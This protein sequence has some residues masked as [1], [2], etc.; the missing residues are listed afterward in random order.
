MVIQDEFGGIILNLGPFEG[1]GTTN[2]PGSLS[3]NSSFLYIIY[4]DINPV[5]IRSFTDELSLQFLLLQNYPNPFNPNTVIKYALPETRNVELIIYN[6]LGEKVKTLVSE[7]QEAGYY[8][9]IWNA[10][11][12]YGSKVVSGL[13]ICALK[14]GDYHSVKKMMLVK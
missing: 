2:I 6:A 11:N 3:L 4:S 1:A 5:E 14:A 13:Y 12:D 9:I 8:S 7:I 10:T